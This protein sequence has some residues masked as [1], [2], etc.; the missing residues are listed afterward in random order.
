MPQVFFWLL[1][2]A[3]AIG[4]GIA[5]GWLMQDR[6]HARRMRGLRAGQ[7]VRIVGAGGIARAQLKSIGRRGLR[8]GAPLVLDRAWNPE[9]GQKIMVQAPSDEG[10]ISFSARILS[11]NASSGEVLIESPGYLKAVE[12][13]CEPRDAS[14]AGTSAMVNGHAGRIIN[15]SAS[16]ARLM[17]GA[18]IR[19]GD[20]VDVELPLGLG[21]AEGWALSVE[22]GFE[23]SQRDVRIRFDRP[24]AGLT[25]Q[26]RR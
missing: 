19:P 2:L 11:V 24:L 5:A 16:G 21:L 3:C 23:K 7:P 1:L 15:L 17:T 14:C 6:S 25:L 12:R 8:L 9:P 22:P 13:R 10:V 26:P 20:E 18:P 4:S